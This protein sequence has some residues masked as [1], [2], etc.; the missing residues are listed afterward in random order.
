MGIQIMTKSEGYKGG[1]IATIVLTSLGLVGI[2]G[3]L[4]AAAMGMIPGVTV[5]IP[6]LPALPF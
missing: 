2:L 1:A 4:A 3:G 5:P 6:A